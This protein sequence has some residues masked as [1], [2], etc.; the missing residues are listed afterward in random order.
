MQQPEQPHGFLH[1][2]CASAHGHIPLIASRLM[3]QCLRAGHRSWSGMHNFYNTE[4]QWGEWR[5]VLIALQFCC[6]SV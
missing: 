3:G 5:S 4:G 1:L 6:P 2:G